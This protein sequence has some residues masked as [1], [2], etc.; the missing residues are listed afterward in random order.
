MKWEVKMGKETHKDQKP[1]VAWFKD[2]SIDD[3]PW[4]GV[5]M[6]AWGR[7]TVI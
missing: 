2:L 6:P 5:R 1:F 3:V 7:C 4:W